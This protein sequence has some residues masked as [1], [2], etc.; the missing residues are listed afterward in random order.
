MPAG[1]RA[2]VSSSAVES[3]REPPAQSYRSIYKFRTKTGN[4]Q[5]LIGCRGFLVFTDWPVIPMI[6][7]SYHLSDWPELPSPEAWL[8]D[9][10]WPSAPLWACHGSG[11]VVTMH[12][13]DVGMKDTHE[14]R[15]PGALLSRKRML[16]RMSFSKQYI[17]TSVIKWWKNQFWKMAC[18]TQGLESLFH[19]IA[20]SPWL[21]FQGLLESLNDLRE[22]SASQCQK[23]CHQITGLAYSLLHSSLT[24]TCLPYWCSFSL[25][26]YSSTVLSQPHS[27]LA[28]ANGCLHQ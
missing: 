11:E 1:A 2:P 15:W 19:T 10:F 6:G 3:W 4:W 27:K 25:T 5:G 16:N 7:Q 12:Y 20:K 24:S 26:S 8:R 21:C 23:Y 28:Q 22:A 9:Y 14:W 13:F 17:S 18:V